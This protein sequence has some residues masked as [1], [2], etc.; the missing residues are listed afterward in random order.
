M[1]DLLDGASHSVVRQKIEDVISCPVCL[2][3]C[4]EPRALPCYHAFCLQCLQSSVRRT[5]GTL[6]CPQ[7]RRQVELPKEGVSGLRVAFHINNLIEIYESIQQEAARSPGAVAT[8]LSC[9]NCAGSAASHFCAQCNK[10]LC[11]DC[12]LVHDKWGQFSGH[13]ISGMS[14]KTLSERER[15]CR[16]HPSQSLTH[17]CKGCRQLVCSEC[18]RESDGCPHYQHKVSITEAA[19]LAKDAI[20]ASLEPIRSQL[21]SIEGV[22]RRIQAKKQHVDEQAADMN[23]AIDR[24]FEDLSSALEQRRSELKLEVNKE[25]EGKHL[26]LGAQEERAEIARAQLSNYLEGI[27]QCLG[28]GSSVGVI[29]IQHTVQERVREILQEFGG[30]PQSPVEAAD[31]RYYASSRELSSTISSFGLVCLGDVAAA[32][33]SVLPKG[34][35]WATAC[36]EA[37]IAIT[38]LGPEGTASENKWLKLGLS[39]EDGSNAA[40]FETRREVLNSGKKVVIHYIPFAKGKK[41]LH[42]TLFGTEVSNSPLDLRVMGPF[43]FTGTLIRCVRELRRPWGLAVS[44]TGQL[45][46]IDNQG[47]QTVHLYGPTDSQSHSFGGM[48]FLQTPE[49]L[50]TDKLCNEPRGVAFTGDGKILV[51]DGKRHRVVCYAEDGTFHSKAGSYGKGPLQFNDPVGITVAPSGHVLVCDRRNHRIQVLSSSDLIYICQIGQF[52]EGDCSDGLYLPWDVACD[53]EGRIYVADCGN[54]CVK[55]FTSDGKFLKKIGGPGT[56]RGQFQH[57]SS[58]CIDSN[59]YLYAVDM[60]RSCVSVFDPQGEFKMEFGTFGQLDGQFFK[61]H[62]IAVDRGGHV[63]VSDGDT[64][65]LNLLVAGGGRVQVFQ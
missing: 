31:L 51:V 45:A 38:H 61:P 33:F 32:E 6:A 5:G 24:D 41:Q 47:W 29:R 19:H 30:L 42:V 35:Q 43:R 22:V 49:R 20:L 2:E 10:F 62:G 8:G 18:L 39:S 23:A 21:V 15:S 34:C 56:E 13:E 25:E 52:G 9:A 36:D 60:K 1:A 50:K 53:S 48:A 58:I 3:I 59:D 57:I 27:S 46:V 54:C 40:L 11:E 37:S 17:Y 12:R 7:C 44:E 28:R 26:G 55:V 16:T 63:Y 64:S 4:R 14:E 65:P